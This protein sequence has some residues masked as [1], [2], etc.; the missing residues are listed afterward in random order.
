MDY[1]KTTDLDSDIHIKTELNSDDEELKISG[2][3]IADSTLLSPK[4][5]IES[6]LAVSAE[7]LYDYGPTPE[8]MLQNNTNILLRKQQ[9][10]FERSGIPNPANKN[11]FLWTIEEVSEFISHLPGC[12]AIKDIFVKHEIDGEALLCLKYEDLYTDMNLRIGPSV[13]IIHQILQ[14]RQIVQEKYMVV[15]TISNVHSLN[16]P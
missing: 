7:Q 1:Q 15:N 13:K 2:I 14:L 10:N 8:R 6:P 16:K 11:P 4:N 12:R 9:E 5:G 3:R